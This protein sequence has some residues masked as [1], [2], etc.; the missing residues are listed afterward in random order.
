M[1]FF[2]FDSVVVRLERPTVVDTYERDADSG[3]VD[4]P[5]LDFWRF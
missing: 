4:G 1:D 2:D 5:F 3:T